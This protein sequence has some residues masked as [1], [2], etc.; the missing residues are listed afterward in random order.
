[1]SAPTNLYRVTFSGGGA[2]VPDFSAPNYQ[3]AQTAAH[4]FCSVMQRTDGQLVVV[5]QGIP[6]VGP[7]SVGIAPANVPLTSV[8][9]G[10][11]F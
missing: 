3:A 8:P 6:Y 4:L 9:S 7:A 10:M 11:T 2:P 5:N 1:M